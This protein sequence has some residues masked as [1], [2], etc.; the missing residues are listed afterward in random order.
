MY[1]V[2]LLFIRMPT[3]HSKRTTEKTENS[4]HDDTVLLISLHPLGV[5][6]KGV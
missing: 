1:T 4:T 6:A 3:N 5:T 2:H